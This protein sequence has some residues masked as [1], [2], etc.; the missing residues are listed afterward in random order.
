MPKTCDECQS[1]R[2]PCDAEN[3]QLWLNQLPPMIQRMIERHPP[4]CYRAGRRKG[5][6]YQPQLYHANG[7]ITVKHLEGSSR[8]AG[9]MVRHIDPND[10]ERC[11]C[12]ATGHRQVL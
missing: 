8:P 4:S 12:G 11:D 10:L 1:V 5:S 2:Q 3:F 7:T 6:H 9:V